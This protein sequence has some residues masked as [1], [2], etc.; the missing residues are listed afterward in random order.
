MSDGMVEFLQVTLIDLFVR[1]KYRLTSRDE[2]SNPLF[3]ANA[4]PYAHGYN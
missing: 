3:E 2:H 1:L 4:T